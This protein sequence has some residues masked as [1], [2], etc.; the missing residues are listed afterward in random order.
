MSANLLAGLNDLE[1]IGVRS[2]RIYPL[3]D[4]RR[5]RCGHSMRLPGVWSHPHL[6]QSGIHLNLHGFRMRL[7]GTAHVIA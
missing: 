6:V 3:L 2:D 7:L 4:G 5:N 1:L